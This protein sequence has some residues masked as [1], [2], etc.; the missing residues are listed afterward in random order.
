MQIV[1]I[2]SDYVIILQPLI[3]RVFFKILI[4]Q[5]HVHILQ[6]NRLNLLQQTSNI[7]VKGNPNRIEV[8]TFENVFNKN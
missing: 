8:D 3:G 1:F 7:L 5:Y 6:V 4:E 2:I